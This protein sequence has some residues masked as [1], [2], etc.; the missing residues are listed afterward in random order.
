MSYKRGTYKLIKSLRPMDVFDIVTRGICAEYKPEI[1]RQ[2]VSIRG[3]W[4]LDN[5]GNECKI[6]VLDIYLSDSGFRLFVTR[7]E[8]ERLL[9]EFKS[10]GLFG[11][12]VWAKW[13][14]GDDVYTVGF[15]YTHENFDVL[16]KEWVR[17]RKLE[18][19]GI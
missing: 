12:Q 18:E 6:D 19:I 2:I 16:Y 4:Y 1:E 10:W 17:N 14:G 15:V 8:S 13:Y 5:W 7:K 3:K 9:K 11:D